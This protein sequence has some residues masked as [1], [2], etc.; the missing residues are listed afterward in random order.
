MGP[1]GFD[2]GVPLV[3]EDYDITENVRVNFGARF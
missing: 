3:K 1:I 2:F